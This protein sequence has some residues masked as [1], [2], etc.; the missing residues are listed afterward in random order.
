MLYIFPVSDVL[1]DSHTVC[2]DR[3]Y[4]KRRYTV[5]L[6]E[7]P[8]DLPPGN[9]TPLESNAVFLNGGMLICASIKYILVY[10]VNSCNY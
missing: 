2:D 8:V 7:G 10:N 6:S 9:C 1:T 3:T 5:G 4:N